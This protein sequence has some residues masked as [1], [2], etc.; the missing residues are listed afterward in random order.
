MLPGAEHVTVASRTTRSRLTTAGSKPGC[1][2]ARDEEDRSLR[3]IATGMRSSRTCGADT[4]NSPPT[5]P[6][7][8]EWRSRSP[9]S[10]SR[11]DQ[12]AGQP[13]PALPRSTN[14]Q[15]PPTPD[16]PPTRPPPLPQ[17]SRSRLPARPPRSSTSPGRPTNPPT[18]IRERTT[19]GNP[20]LPEAWSWSCSMRC[21]A[22]SRSTS[23]AFGCTRGGGADIG[24]DPADPA[25]L[26]TRHQGVAPPQRVRGWAGWPV[27][28]LRSCS[29]TPTST[30]SAARSCGQPA[31]LT[32]SPRRRRREWACPTC[33]A[34]GTIRIAG[35]P[36]TA[37]QHAP[38]GLP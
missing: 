7:L 16:P 9:S 19:S 14:A 32:N 15:C 2:H 11:S 35:H 5:P 24:P 1:D 25:A 21:S 10:P 34:A 17:P 37:A 13:L 18:T 33:R 29:P 12:P 6:P 27:C 23:R 31:A 36:T 3:I 22:P 38:A 30:T 26:P 4:T 28:A 20:D 8:I